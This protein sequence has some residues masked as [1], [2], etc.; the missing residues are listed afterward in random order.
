VWRVDER[1]DRKNRVQEPREMGDPAAEYAERRKRL[2]ELQFNLNDHQS[3][4]EVISSKR[5]EMLEQVMR[6]KQELVKLVKMNLTL[7]DKYIAEQRGLISEQDDHYRGLRGAYFWTLNVLHGA[8]EGIG[9]SKDSLRF[10]R[11]PQVDLSC[12]DFRSVPCS[13][14]GSSSDCRVN[15]VACPRLEAVD[16]SLVCKCSQDCLP[17]CHSCFAEDR[18][19]QMESL[20]DSPDNEE[21]SCLMKC[22]HC[23][24]ALCPYKVTRVAS[25]EALMRFIGCDANPSALD[26]PGDQV[27]PEPTADQEDRSATLRSNLMIS[28]SNEDLIELILHMSETLDSLRAGRSASSARNASRSPYQGKKIGRAK[29]PGTKK[30]ADQGPKTRMCK[31]CGEYGHYSKRCRTNPEPRDGDSPPMTVYQ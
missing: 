22:L 25:L 2:A 31:A 10:F 16:P 6:G 11:E 30:P 17:F 21:P 4:M 13:K 8:T 7:T 3:K 1:S 15:E 14:C 27:E 5:D 9:E 12:P 23:G 18:N 28:R 26:V 20:V 29:K 19:R 24:G